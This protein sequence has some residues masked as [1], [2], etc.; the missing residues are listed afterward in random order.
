M[1]NG[2]EIFLVSKEIRRFYDALLM[3]CGLLLQILPFFKAPYNERLLFW[4]SVAIYVIKLIDLN[5]W[6]AF[7]FGTSQPRCT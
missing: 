5:D 1:A 6:L 7:G 2:N 4:L 3:I